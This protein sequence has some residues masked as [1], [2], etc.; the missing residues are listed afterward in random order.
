MMANPT[1]PAFRY[2]PYSKEITREEYDH[3]LMQRNRSEAIAKAS[4]AQTFGIILGTLGRQGSSK[5][6]DAVIDVIEKRGL[7]H[8]TILLSEVFPGKLDA[9]GDA[10][11]AFVQ[12]ACPRLS[13]DWG[14]FF[15]K[16]LLTPYE[17]AV[18]LGSA[19]WMPD[20]HYPMDFYAYASTGKWTP[21]YRD[22]TAVTARPRKPHIVIGQAKAPLELVQVPSV[23]GCGNGGADCC[24]KH[25]ISDC[26]NSGCVYN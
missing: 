22:G 6:L 21:N 16:P 3:V 17:A 19:P 15:A 12:I 2:D 14:T 20:G 8:V 7:T 1:T 23:G 5:V 9:F 24:A 4:K 10:V 18:A 11:D 13:I 25:E 26:T